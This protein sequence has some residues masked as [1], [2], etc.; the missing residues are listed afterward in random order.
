VEK[1]LPLELSCF[2][3]THQEWC[4]KMTTVLLVEDNE[5]V[6]NLLRRVLH[7]YNYTVLEAENAAEALELSQGH[8]DPIDLLLV[9]ILLPQMPAAEL[10]EQLTAVRPE[11]KVL[12]MSGYPSETLEEQGLLKPGWAFLQKPFRPDTLLDTVRRLLEPP[13]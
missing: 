1:H 8:A 4:L 3:V 7:H 2:K 11:L 9:D 13:G 6:R 10:I 12:C 5:A